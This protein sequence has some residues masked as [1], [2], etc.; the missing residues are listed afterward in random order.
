MVFEFA[1][2]DEEMKFYGSC[3][4]EAGRVVEP[5][6]VQT[7][8]KV[9]SHHPFAGIPPFLRRSA[10]FPRLRSS[11]TCSFTQ[12]AIFYHFLSS[13]QPIVGDSLQV[14][15]LTCLVNLLSIFY[16]SIFYSSRCSAS[17][18]SMIIREAFKLTSTI[19]PTR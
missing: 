14:R 8:H 6:V 12:S 18:L 1:Y 11:L 19:L 15:I 16:C 4:I 7:V 2:H 10:R 13:G 17:Q 9:R 3:P 5:R